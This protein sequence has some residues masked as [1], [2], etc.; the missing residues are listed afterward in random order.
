MEFRRVGLYVY[1]NQLRLF[2]SH[3]ITLLWPNDPCSLHPDAHISPRELCKSDKDAFARGLTKK[4]QGVWARARVAA[5]VF[6]SMRNASV[7]SLKGISGSDRGERRQC[8]KGRLRNWSP[9]K[10]RTSVLSTA[11]P[12]AAPSAATGCPHIHLHVRRVSAQPP[13]HK[14]WFV[15]PFCWIIL[16]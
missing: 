3:S 1:T 6:I 9:R 4:N 2:E 12:S 8:T 7:R 10:Q 5:P 11:A 13:G 16:F 15:F 14:D